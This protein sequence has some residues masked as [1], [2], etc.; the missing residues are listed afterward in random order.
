MWS[1]MMSVPNFME[2]EPLTQLRLLV[3]W[4]SVPILAL[5]LPISVDVMP[6]IPYAQLPGPATPSQSP[7]HATD[8]SQT[9][10]FNIGPDQVRPAGS[11]MSSTNMGPPFAD[12]LIPLLVQPALTMV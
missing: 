12:G 1:R 2:C 8:L 3:S 6:V 7:L 5:A 11:G 4:K 9:L 10:R